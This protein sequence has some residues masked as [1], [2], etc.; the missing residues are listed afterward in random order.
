MIS[1]MLGAFFPAALWAQKKPVCA[2]LTSKEVAAA[3][4]TGHGAEDSV[5]IDD[6]PT[7]GERI[8][9]CNWKTADGQISLSIARMPPGIS[10]EALIAQLDGTYA[11]LRAQGWKEEKKQFGTISCSLMTPPASRPDMPI[12][13][14]CITE[15]KGK[16]VSIATLGKTRIPMEKAKALVESA[17]GRL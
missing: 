9:L 11:K 16:V 4:A 2:L 14:G 3:G 8:Q 5:A 7:K 10:R 15:T 13:T 12:T 1:V 17:G 6:G